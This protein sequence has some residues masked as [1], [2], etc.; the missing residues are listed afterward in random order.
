MDE[1]FAIGQLLRCRS[2]VSHRRQDQLSA[3]RRRNSANVLDFI[4]IP[5]R[6]FGDLLC[7][8][9]SVGGLSIQGGIKSEKGRVA[10]DGLGGI[11]STLQCHNSI[12]VDGG[13]EL[14]PKSIDGSSLQAQ[15]IL[16]EID[17]RFGSLAPSRRDRNR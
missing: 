8:A 12:L 11:Q 3:R 15:P 4:Y 1:G 6:L 17:N 14:D 5:V 9:P 10:K 7:R 13:S 2:L 16:Q